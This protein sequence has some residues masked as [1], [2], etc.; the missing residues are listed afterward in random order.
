MNLLIV[1]DDAI[2][3]MTLQRHLRKL[4]YEGVKAVSS[5]T[6]ALKIVQQEGIDLVFMDIFIEGDWDG[7]ETVQHI[8]RLSPNTFIT[9]ITASSDQSNFGRALE[10]K[11]LGFLIKPAD[12]QSLELQI[13]KAL[14]LRQQR[15]QLQSE[16]AENLLNMIYDSADIGMCLTDINRRF[17]KVN[18]AYCRTYGYTKDEL[19]G[20]EF[21]KVLPEHLRE[22]AS[23]LHDRYLRYE[24][25]ESAGE[26]QVKCK[27]GS[28]KDIYVTAARMHSRNGQIFKVTT[29]ADIT[30]KKRY[31]QKLES[32]LAEKEQ[33]VR[34]VHHRVKNNLNIVSGLLYMQAEKVEEQPQVYGLFTESINRIRTLSFIHEKLYKRDNLA[35]ID[36]KDYL[37]SLASNIIN[38]FNSTKENV[39]LEMQLAAVEIDIDRCI[40]CGLIVNE[41]LSNAFKHA[42]P[43]GS[44]GLIS[45][46]LK[47]ENNT[48]LLEIRDN[49][50]GLPDDFHIESSGTLGM[51]LIH[52]LSRQLKATLEISASSGTAFRLTFNIA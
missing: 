49:G 23:D 38:T 45:L 46:T 39:R 3:Q 35:C 2:A 19:V 37:Q 8:N 15:E 27:D 30:E 13:Q 6:E 17:V 52:N 36:L 7:I 29:V 41:V 21:T 33:L 47:Q 50:I 10:T 40:S 20:F 31:T 28:I 14:S 44:D 12:A 9:F 24:T 22:Y 16:E 48:L 25:E 34:E 43:E 42:F 18:K 11:H 51:Q 5:G 32:I 4:G 1:E 26:W